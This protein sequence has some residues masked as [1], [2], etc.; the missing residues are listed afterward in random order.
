[1]IKGKFVTL[2]GKL[3]T[4]RDDASKTILTILLSDDGHLYECP[5]ENIH[6]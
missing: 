1:M 3:K 4:I 5:K 2:S 6:S